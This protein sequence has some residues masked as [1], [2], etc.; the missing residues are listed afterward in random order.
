MIGL[1]AAAI[2]RFF[3]VLTERS[4][5]AGEDRFCVEFVD[6]VGQLPFSQDK[7]QKV[8][9]EQWIAWGMI[10]GCLKK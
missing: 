3:E 6:A 2:R 9:R 4:R 1:S 8:Q 10:T 7:L 5:L